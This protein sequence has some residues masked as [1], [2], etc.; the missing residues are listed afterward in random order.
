[1]NFE[2]LLSGSLVLSL[3]GN[4]FGFGPPKPKMRS[5]PRGPPRL[6]LSIGSISGTGREFP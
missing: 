4:I 5:P 2:V 3:E 1:V 6:P